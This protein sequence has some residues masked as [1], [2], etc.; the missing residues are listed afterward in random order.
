MRD[1]RVRRAV[2]VAAVAG[3][4]LLSLFSVFLAVDVVRSHE[5]LASGDDD[6]VSA[7][8]RGS[9]WESGGLGASTISRKVLGVDDD[10][11]FREAVRAL[12]LSQRDEPTDASPEAILRRAKAQKLLQDVS[13]SDPDVR[14]RSRALSLL[15]V[16]MLSTPA[17]DQEERATTQ[18]V[19]LANLQKAI[20]IDPTNDE[21]KYNLE[22]V[23]R[24]RA[25]VQQVQGG[26]SP[27]PSSGQGQSRGAA[28]G[29]PGK[30]Y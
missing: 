9:L 3:C 23:L 21:A 22:A 25:G 16:L 29:P 12:R 2:L 15:S 6:Y 28:T 4:A 18:R 27:N 30:G 24:R 7:P 5:A 17:A 20:E 1:P 19:A 8:K 26:P 11:R 14:R 10:L 13:T